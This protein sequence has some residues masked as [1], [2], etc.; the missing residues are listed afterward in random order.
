MIDEPAQVPEMRKR[1]LAP[2]FWGTILAMAAL[3][4]LLSVMAALRQ[5]PAV[6]E[7]VA[8]SPTPIEISAAKLESLLTNAN[9]MTVQAVMRQIGPLV[10]LA[11]QPAYD[12]IPAYA[13]FH[14]SVWGEYTELSAAALGAVTGKLEEMLL[15]GLGARLE[16]VGVKLDDHFA[17]AFETELATAEE[18]SKIS[19]GPLTTQTMDSVLAR[20]KVTVPVG[21]VA[22][23]GTAMAVKSVAKVIAKKI[24]A[25]LAIKT[26]AK[27]GGKWAAVGTAGGS[28][29]FLCSWS[30]PGSAVC[31]IIGGIGAWL[32]TDY[33]IVKLDEYWTRDEFEADLRLMLDEQKAA[34]KAALEQALV[35]K[36]TAVQDVSDAA[37]QHQD[38]TLRELSGVGNEEICK[39]AADLR[40]RYEPMRQ[41]LRARSPEALQALRAAMEPHLGDLT[42]GRL[43]R[44]ITANLLAATELTVAAA[45]IQ[46][47]LPADDRADRDVSGILVM[48]GQ[49][50]DIPEIPATSGF[51]IDLPV[52][53]TLK[54]DQPLTLALSLEQH[55]W[56]KD[57]YFGTG[58][59][60]VIVR[61]DGNAPGLSQIATFSLPIAHDPDANAVQEVD[62]APQ[63][64]E[65]IHFTLDLRAE[66]LAG[67]IDGPAC[68]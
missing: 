17:S 12:A 55:L 9:Q 2:W 7:K 15:A 23:L 3:S 21:T 24:A 62:I 57:P 52:G 34:Q 13:D 19:I 42:L 61:S 58:A 44:E 66:A 63:N 56:L 37:V 29:A 1:R 33:T 68:Q 31:G 48:N 51:S 50:I 54:L 45:H 22:S 8:S 27:A 67:L 5:E 49:S 38:F 6:P 4:V 59:K 25:K 47:N 65:L 18:A 40:A 46:G 32:I 26:A 16:N 28:G 11:Y 36:A 41:Y 64:G 43:V 20:M 14:Y 35:L 30:G 10:D 39:V 53:V 60:N